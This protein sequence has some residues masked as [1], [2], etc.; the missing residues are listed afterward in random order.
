VFKKVLSFVLD[1]KLFFFS[2]D[3][4]KNFLQNF[5]TLTFNFFEVFLKKI[6][7]QKN[8]LKYFLIKF[9]SVLSVQS[10]F[11]DADSEN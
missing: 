1:L 5:V 9:Q 6:L 7:K 8:F 2:L 3:F 10:V 11:V 4:Q